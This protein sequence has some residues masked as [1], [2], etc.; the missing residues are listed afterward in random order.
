MKDEPILSICIPTYK[1][2]NELRRC[3][4]S[5]DFWENIE[6]VVSEN[7]SPIKN[8]TLN[9]LSTYMTQN[10]EKR[11]IIS[12]NEI[13]LGYDG[14]IQKLITLANGKYIMFLCDDD[15]LI[16]G[17]LKKICEVLSLR[18][19]ALAYIPFLRDGRE[20]RKYDSTMEIVGNEKNLSCHLGDA[21][22]VSGLIFMKNLIKDYKV[23]DLLNCNYFQ[24][25]LF[26]KVFL[27]YGATYLDVLGIQ[28]IS[29]GENAFGYA[30]ASAGEENCLIQDRDSLYSDI[31][32]HKGLVKV[33]K[34]VDREEN[35]KLVKS[36]S[37]KYCVGVLE[38]LVVASEIDGIVGIKKYYQLVLELGIDVKIY[39]HICYLLLI[40]LGTNRTKK[41]L[42]KIKEMRVKLKH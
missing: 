4:E 28:Y 16:T 8:E 29:D 36:F 5:I 1:R 3:I 18:E 17:A 42:G 20:E 13:N 12:S 9:M 39:V 22:L 7:N 33:I 37:K 10:V 14:N 41:L 23:G 31:G 32:F 19:M 25:Y 15:I 11:I 35:T 6:V 21:I 26:S 30:D 34:K 38:K 24:V 2:V 27:N 40:I